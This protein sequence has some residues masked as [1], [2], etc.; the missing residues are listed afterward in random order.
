VRA[1]RAPPRD[2]VADFFRALRY[3]GQTAGD[4]FPAKREESVDPL[5]MVRLQPL[6]ERTEGRPEVR[7]GLI[8]GPVAASPALSQERIS[9]LTGA[10]TC[11]STSI[12]CA[13]G[14]FVAAL[15][16]AKRDSPVRGICPG[17]T[18]L[19][20]PIFSE[21]APAATPAELAAAVVDCV[22][23]GANILNISAAFGEPSVRGDRTL[24]DTLDYAAANGVIT[25]VAA[26]NQGALGSTAITRHPGLIPVVAYDRHARPMSL[27]NFGAV[28][29][30]RG[31]G[32]PGDGIASLA[33]DGRIV[34]MAGT[35]AA[36]PFVSGTVALLWSEF[37]SATAADIRL[38]VM[39]PRRRPS[40]VPPL[41]EC[42]GALARLS[43]PC[44]EAA[45]SECVRSLT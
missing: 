3:V 18:L 7:I 2:F 10:A 45:R 15:L 35:S 29:G 42:G 27:S 1:E 4:S 22:R 9:A 11:A 16:A 37:P 34:T 14:T 44:R 24:D 6:M 33:P 30:R 41:L 19:V 31:I 23:A 43:R 13:H 25:V 32:A 26:G 5:A 28:I 21:T 12:A 38:A 39:G 40:V 36:A 8:D 17:C 20:R